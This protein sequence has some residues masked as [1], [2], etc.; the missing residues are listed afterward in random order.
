[1]NS[2]LLALNVVIPIF[3]M[4]GLGFIAKYF[5]WLKSDVIEGIN[6]FLFRVPM[7]LLLFFSIYSMDLKAIQAK[8]IVF[9][10]IYAIFAVIIVMIVA[11]MMMKQFRTIPN[12][13]KSVIAQVFFRGNVIIF[14]VPVVA[15]IYGSSNTGIISTLAMAIIPLVNILSVILFEYYKKEE[16]DKIHLILEIFKNPL[17]IASIAGFI[18]LLFEIKIPIQIEEPLRKIGN[19]TTP[20]AFVLLGGTIEFS[21]L[22]KNKSILAFGCIER[23]I[24]IPGIIL[25]GAILLGFRGIYLGSLLGAMAAPVAVVS[26]PMAKEMGGDGNLAAQFVVTTT[27]FSIATIFF[28]V[29]L[30][31]SIHLI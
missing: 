28:W 16:I 30:L 25:G 6:S 24:L 29:F 27:L 12:N 31:D 1:M 18:F 23:L 15:S 21:S 13:Q 8:K 26:F 7:P 19:I 22:K 17:V 20:I 4:L 3:I 2:F 14:G 11:I 5:G 9:L 10:D